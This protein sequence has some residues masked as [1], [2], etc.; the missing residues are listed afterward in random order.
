MKYIL[1]THKIT[2]ELLSSKRDDL[3]TLEEVA[4]E[5]NPAKKGRNRIEKSNIKI[6]SLAEKHLTMMSDLMKSTETIQT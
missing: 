1:D 2:K 4:L 5:F 6:V 3:F